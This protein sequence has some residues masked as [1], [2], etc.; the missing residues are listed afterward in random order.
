[1]YSDTRKFGN[2][3]ED[4]AVRKLEQ[5]GFAILERNYLKKWGEIDIVARGTD[6]IVE[7]KSA[8]FRPAHHYDVPRDTFMPEE[9]VTREKLLKLNRVIET[10]LSEH[11]YTGEWQIDVMTVSIDMERRVGHC[12]LIEKVI[13]D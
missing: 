6:K 3:G 11:K 5:L 1:M 2:I 8:K 12:K 4:I 13:C 9:N 7:V 10:W